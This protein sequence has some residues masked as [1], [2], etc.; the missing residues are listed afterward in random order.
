MRPLCVAALLSFAVIGLTARA[1]E[2]SEKDAIR[3]S[4]VSALRAT[5]QVHVAWSL[6]PS[7]S[8]NQTGSSRVEVYREGDTIGATLLGTG[9]EARMVTRGDVIVWTTIEDGVVKSTSFLPGERW[10]KKDQLAWCAA[11]ELFNRLWGYSLDAT[12]AWET[13]FV[14]QYKGDSLSMELTASAPADAAVSWLRSEEFEGHLEARKEVIRLTREG[15]VTEIRRSNGTLHSI[16]RIKPDGTVAP[17]LTPVK[18]RRSVAEWKRLLAKDCGGALSRPDDGWARRGHVL[19]FSRT[20]RLIL[21]DEPELLR[22]PNRMRTVLDTLLSVL[23]GRLDFDAWVE[24]QRADTSPLT[25]QRLRSAAESV[26][27]PVSKAVAGDLEA[28]ELSEKSR[29]L[30]G[31]FV[32]E[33]IFMRMRTVL[34][35]K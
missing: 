3:R 10:L 30:V 13:G 12:H 26:W 25:E 4:L 9:T 19:Q 34:E 31:T 2:A 17:V 18:P 23:L 6:A 1:E 20:L 8:D 15:V 22:R 14:L 7:Q 27:A 24:A 28:L 21:R 32:W 29:E 35:T 5:R 11:V 16:G 33:Y